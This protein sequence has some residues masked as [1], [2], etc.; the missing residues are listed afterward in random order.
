VA[1]IAPVNDVP[2][3]R[4]DAHMHWW[5]TRRS[6]YGWLTPELPSLYRNFG[7]AE[8][9]PLLAASQI[10]GV[11][12]VQA[13]PTVA[14]THYLLELAKP[15]KYVLGVVGWVDLHQ[16]H[17]LEMLAPAELLVGVRP[18]LQDLPDPSWILQAALRPSIHLLEDLDLAFEALITPEHLPFICELV[19]RHPALRVI[20]DHAAQPNI[21]MQ[22]MQPWKND[23]ATLAASPR[24]I[25]KLSG[26]VTTTPGS[27]RDDIAPYVDAVFEV[28][29]PERV[30]WGSDWPVLTQ[31]LGY[32]TWLQWAEHLTA[33]LSPN[34]RDRVFGDNARH[35]YGSR[36]RQEPKRIE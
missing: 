25:C 1:R 15:R 7:P 4:I 12:L 22:S 34:A 28:F 17:E 9:E 5:T 2:H 13:A 16:A 35:F 18:M 26:L 6:D 24:V 21:G 14:E 10:D 3:P 11:I 31:R 8:A 36:L 23:L 27:T 19:E 32:A 30:V 20:V 33:S 29:G